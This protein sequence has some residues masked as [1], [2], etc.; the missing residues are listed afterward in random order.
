MC[1]MLRA[2]AGLVLKHLG[3]CHLYRAEIGIGLNLDWIRTIANFLEFVLD[4]EYNSLQNLGSGPDLDGVIEKKWAVLLW[5]GCIFQIFLDFIWTWAIF[6]KSQYEKP[7]GLCLDLDQDC[8]VGIFTA[9]FQ[10]FGLF[11]SCLAW[12]N[13]VWHVRHSLA[14]FGLFWCVVMKKHCL[15]FFETSGSVT[16]F[17][18][19]L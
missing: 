7:F 19:E 9:K 14:F 8:Q 12:K 11:K 1:W 15:A 18:L 4:S 3:K 13:G 2:M 16:A 10:K 6:V 5:K 17:G